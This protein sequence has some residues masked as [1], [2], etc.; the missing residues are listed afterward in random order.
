LVSTGLNHLVS[1]CV[2]VGFDSLN[3]LVSACVGVAFDSLNHLVSACVRAV[4]PVET[5]S[6][7]DIAGSVA[8][9]Q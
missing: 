5:T 4:E 1:A 7:N 9:P 8:S 2:G 3:H 6:P